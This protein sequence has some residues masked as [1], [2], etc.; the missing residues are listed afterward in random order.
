MSNFVDIVRSMV[1]RQ[2][3]Y[4]MYEQELE[5]QQFIEIEEELEE[6]LE[7]EQEDMNLLEFLQ[8]QELNLEEQECATCIECIYKKI[9]VIRSCK[10]LKYDTCSI[11]LENYKSRQKINILQCNHIFHIK[12]LKKWLFT[13]RNISCPMCRKIIEIKEK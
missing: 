3:D 5:E 13:S 2:I 4:G 10:N 1:E 7:I 9:P 8:E 11:C 6:L 12:C